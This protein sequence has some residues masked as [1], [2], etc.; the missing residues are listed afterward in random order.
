[1]PYDEIVGSV[2]N[3]VWGVDASGKELPP[4]Y[5]IFGNELKKTSGRGL[6][7]DISNTFINPFTITI[8]DKKAI[9]IYENM[10]LG[11]PITNRKANINGVKLKPQEYADWIVL[12]KRTKHKEF[13]YLNFDE[14][15]QSIMTPGNKKHQKYLAMS[16]NEKYQYLQELNSKAFAIGKEQLLM[17]YPELGIALGTIKDAQDEGILPVQGVNLLQ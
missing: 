3:M 6:I 16:D 7:T 4:K 11:S 17:K 1:M 5:D 15:I 13:K 2:G 8:S 9:H 12:S 14:Y 10:R